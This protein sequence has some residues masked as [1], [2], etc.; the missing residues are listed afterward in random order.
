M[1]LNQTQ[2]LRLLSRLFLKGITQDSLPELLEIPVFDGHFPHANVPPDEAV[3]DEWAADHFHLFGMNVPPNAAMYLDPE[4]ML[5][6]ATSAWVQEM[7]SAA[8]FSHPGTAEGPDHI[9]NELAFLAYLLDQAALVHS[10]NDPHGTGEWTSLAARFYGQHLRVWVPVFGFAVQRQQH[11]FY[12]EIAALL[13]KW[14]KEIVAVLPG[15]PEPDLPANEVPGESLLSDPDTHIRD[16]SRYL[17]TPA[18][19]GVLLS[20]DRISHF[21]RSTRLP[22]GFGDRLQ[23]LN[24]LIRSAAGYEMVDGILNLIQ[25]E[26][27]TWLDFYDGLGRHAG[28]DG[29]A[30]FWELR[31]RQSLQ[32]INRMKMEIT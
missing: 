21:G 32:L 22:R 14:V 6:G 9:G 4:A 7:Y 20:R 31:V 26:F 27:E 23:I 24:N 19:S 5:G 1:D 29:T 25:T 10:E 30:R 3:L 8:G 18:L 28:M 12:D 17:L 2:H 15:L 16:I 11:P 13:L